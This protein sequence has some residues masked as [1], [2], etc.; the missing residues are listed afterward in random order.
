MKIYVDEKAQ[1][2][3]IV[4]GG[5]HGQYAVVS[6][7]VFERPGLPALKDN[8]HNSEVVYETPG[9]KVNHV[10]VFSPAGGL[11]ATAT[12]TAQAQKIADALNASKEND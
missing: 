12:S 3:R 11:V 9:Y 1:E 2:V 8:V 6:P 5:G 4:W 10:D 7:Y